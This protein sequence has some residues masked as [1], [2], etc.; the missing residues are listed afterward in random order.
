MRFRI[1]AAL[2][3]LFSLLAPLHAADA[4]N[5]EA[6]TPPPPRLKAGDVAPNFTLPDQEG[7]KVSLREFRGKKTV[8]LA[9]YVF[10]FTDG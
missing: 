3:A 10:A 9:F 1:A 2:L 6:T 8:V 4:K 7:K 5:S